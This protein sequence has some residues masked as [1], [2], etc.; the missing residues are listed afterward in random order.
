MKPIVG[1]CLA[2]VFVVIG[3]GGRFLLPAAGS[4]KS[5]REMASARQIQSLVKDYAR[6]VDTLD[7]ALVRRIWSARPEATFIYPRG[8]E[9]G[10]ANI[11]EGVYGRTMGMFSERELLPGEPAIHVYGDAAWSEF[12]WTFQGMLKN[13]G[14][15]V[16]TA[17]RETQIYHKENGTWKIVH[18]HYSGQPVTRPPEGAEPGK[19]R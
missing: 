14:T 15:K 11:L 3:L 5:A 16:T 10:L 7:P 19:T 8:T 4:E 1:P 2:G 18:V 9:H 12:T 17:G 13:G 6:S